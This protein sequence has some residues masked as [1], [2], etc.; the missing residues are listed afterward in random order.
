MLDDDLT[1][2]GRATCRTAGG[3]RVADG[4]YYH[5]G[6]SW[7]RFEHGGRVRVGIDDFLVRLCGAPTG[8]DLP[9][10]G[11]TLMQNQV[12]LAIARGDRQA[13]VLAPVSGTV[14]AVNHLVDEHPE[15][16]HADPYDEGWL[17]MVEPDAVRANMKGLF[18]GTTCLTW[19]EHESDRLLELIGPN[20]RGLAA[21]G[22]RAIADV[23]GR[24]PQ[25]GWDRLV[26]E[27]LHTRDR[28]AR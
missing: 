3:Y 22:G 11:E 1:G 19:M 10:L 27:F 13:G 8:V 18:C 25:I 17:L 23:F 6:H 9:P 14:L 16:P 28:A 5:M 21:T 20:Y 7:A 12:G 2:N 26:A 15:L 4:Y 24:F